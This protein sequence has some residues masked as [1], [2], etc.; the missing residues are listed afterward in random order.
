MYVIFEG[1]DTSGKSTQIDI[2]CK[3]NPE[4]IA[5]KEPGQTNLGKDIREIILHT[6]DICK[7]AEFFL[8]L[9]DRAEHFK[10]VIEPNIDKIILSDRGF[11]SGMAYAFC[12][13]EKLDLEF[14]LHVNRYALSNTMP[15]KVVLFKTDEELLR[16]RLGKK[17]HD[18]IEKRGID[19]LM[20]VQNSMDE[21]VK[22]LNISSLHVNAHDSIEEITKQIEGFIG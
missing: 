16:S 14:L 1:I 12:N 18:S 10:R 22:Y 17:N 3:K 7:K 19:Y 4:I 15:D 2:F 8:F 21:I 9:A 20:R 5:T 6:H 11:I 13:D